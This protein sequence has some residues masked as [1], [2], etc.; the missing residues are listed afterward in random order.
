[1]GENFMGVILYETKINF[2]F[3]TKVPSCLEFLTAQSKHLRFAV[4]GCLHVNEIYF[5]WDVQQFIMFCD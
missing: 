5:M 4:F 1:M 2:L 3:T